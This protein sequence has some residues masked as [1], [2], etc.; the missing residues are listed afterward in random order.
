MEM[1]KFRIKEWLDER[2]ISIY[3]VRLDHIVET[4]GKEITL[5]TIELKKQ[6]GVALE[7]D[8]KRM[9]EMLWKNKC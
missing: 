1:F 8:K 9:Y 3:F 4:S 6:I 5:K 2:D 7:L